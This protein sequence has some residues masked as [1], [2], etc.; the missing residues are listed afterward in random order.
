MKK[1]FLIGLICASSVVNAEIV[2]NS[3]GEKI[4]LKE[5]G[6]WALIKLTDDDYIVNAKSYTINLKDGNKQEVAVNV[7][8][9]VNLKDGK[10][11]TK[12]RAMF[13]IQLTQIPISFKLKNRYSYT[14]KS[15]YI[16]QDSN[17]V[18]ISIEYLAKNSYGADTVGT[19]TKNFTINE[20]GNLDQI[21]ER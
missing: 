18:R 16:N 6:T 17:N 2:T 12:D 11:L 14:P 3:K 15:V 19:E 8:P 21:I 5:N 7:I 10:K 9:S 20:K 1:L 4:E 13:G